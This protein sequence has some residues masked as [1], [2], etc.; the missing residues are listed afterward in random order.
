MNVPCEKRCEILRLHASP[1]EGSP[2]WIRFFKERGLTPDEVAEVPS[3]AGF[4]DADALRQLPLDEF[5]SRKVAEAGEHL[6]TGE[7][8]GFTGP[9]VTTAFQ[10]AEFTAGF[11][12]PFLR[13]AA[14]IGFPVAGR[15]LWIGPSGPHTIGKAVRAIL[16]EVGGLDPFSVD[17]DPRWFNRLPED[18]MSR[19]RYL[20]HLREQSLRILLRE[21]IE[22]IFATP[23]VIA[24]LA[25]ELPAEKRLAIRGVHYGGMAMTPADYDSFVS[26]FPNAVHLSGYGNSLFGMFPETGRSARGIEYAISSER[27]QLDLLGDPGDPESRAP[28]GG[29]GRVVMSRFD[30]SVLILNLLERDVA[31]RTETGIVNPRPEPRFACR[32]VIY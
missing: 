24:M 6:I 31:T 32:K 28:A 10:R 27:I 9:P 20:D 22:V 26:A 12:T 19:R 23:P 18:S 30:E 4:M 7:S 5:L 15:W 1:D 11:V 13:R 3:R 17:F 16:E 8:G 2:Y 25:G 14:A 21:R 29:E